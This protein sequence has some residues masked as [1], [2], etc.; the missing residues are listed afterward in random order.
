MWKKFTLIILLLP[1]SISLYGSKP[2]IYKI[3]RDFPVDSSGGP[4]GYGYVWIDIYEPGGPVYNWI[5]ITSIGTKVYGLSDDN[6]AGPFPIGFDFPYYGFYVNQFWVNSN[7]AISFTDA[8]V[9]M[10]HGYSGF[11]IPSV[12]L[13]NNLLVPLG[14]DLIFEGVDTAECYYYTNNVDTFIVS[15][16]NVAAWDTGGLTGSHTFQLILTRQDSCIYFEYGKQEGQFYNNADCVGIENGG[17]GLQV[18]YYTMPDSG[19]AVKF[20]PPDSISKISEEKDEKKSYDLVSLHAYPNPAEG[21]IKIFYTLPG[22]TDVNLRVYNLLGQE[23]KILENKKKQAG[24]HTISWNGTNS[25]GRKVPVG[26]YFLKLNAGEYHTTRKLF[27][28]R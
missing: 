25:S 15:Y 28:V 13:P 12:N 8:D 2:K 5:D 3:S 20:Y 17:T 27:K 11:F 24:I 1:I 22:D 18:L 14:A 19:Y 7:G 26:V 10:P 23:V 4:D 6:N 21:N 9:Y 16:I